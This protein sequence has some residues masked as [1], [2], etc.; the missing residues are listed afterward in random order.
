MKD[1][2]EIVDLFIKN[3]KLQITP[4]FFFLFFFE[5]QF[6]LV[7]FDLFI[8]FNLYFYIS[9]GVPA[10]PVVHSL[11]RNWHKSIERW[12]WKKS[13]WYSSLSTHSFVKVNYQWVLAQRE[14]PPW[15]KWVNALFVQKNQR[16]VPFF[17]LLKKKN[18]YNSSSI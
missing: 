14:L 18:V 10:W 1:L 7:T 5:I 2:V 15:P 8:Q 11:T 6:N 9:I 12:H 4:S 13:L 16:F 17:K 3:T